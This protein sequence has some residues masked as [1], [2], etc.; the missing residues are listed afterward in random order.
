[1]N[2]TTPFQTLLSDQNVVELNV[3]NYSSEWT[4]TEHIKTA[5]SLIWVHVDPDKLIAARRA[6][7]PPWSARARPCPRIRSRQAVRP[8][9]AALLNGA[10]RA[11]TVRPAVLIW[12][13]EGAATSGSCNSGRSRRFL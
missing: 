5:P 10:V 8:A 3:N 2:M 12:I 7:T 9:H 11:A 13:N 1:M 6:G 4:A